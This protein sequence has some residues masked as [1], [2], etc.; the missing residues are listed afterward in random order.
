[1]LRHATPMRRRAAA[2]FCRA[3]MTHYTPVYAPLCRRGHYICADAVIS[4]FAQH[5]MPLR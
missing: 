2:L 1:M 3:A 5:L 4:I